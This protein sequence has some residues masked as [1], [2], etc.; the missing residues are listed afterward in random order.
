[1][2]TT[3]GLHDPDGSAGLEGRSLVGVTADVVGLWA[4][5]RDGVV[6]RTDDGEWEEAAS[7]RD[8]KPRCLLPHDDGLLIGTAQAR[9]FRLRRDTV[10]PVEGFD[11]V[12]GRDGWYTPWGGP[13]D[14]R[15]MTADAAGTVY[16]NVHV[17]GIVR[18]APDGGWQPTIDIDTDVHQVIAHPDRPGVVL[19]ATAYGLARSDDT[20]D[21]WDLSDEGLHAPYCRAVAVAGETLLVTASTGPSTRRAAVYRRPLDGQGPFERCET[22][23][24]EWF[25][26][27]LDTHCLASRGS[28]VALG[29]AEGAVWMSRDEGRSWEQA[30]DGLARVTAVLWSG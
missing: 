14:T 16:A 23:L 8:P 28:A 30:E 10:E 13:P 2:A 3:T 24:P 22:G 1:M 17:G 12:P 21:T 7:L 29:T 4:L 26:S 6:L 5:A 11:E 25:T 20:G 19:A 15:S 27:N 9:L 18:S